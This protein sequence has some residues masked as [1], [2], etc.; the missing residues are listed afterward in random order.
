VVTNL[1]FASDKNQQLASGAPG[2]QV[3][4]VP[5]PGTMLLIG[6]GVAGLAI[7]RRRKV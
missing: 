4:Q 2:F 7:S 5:E 3:N 1:T 6:I